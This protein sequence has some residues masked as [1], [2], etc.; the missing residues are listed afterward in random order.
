MKYQWYILF[1]FAIQLNNRQPQYSMASTQALRAL[2]RPM[3]RQATL[4]RP[5]SRLPIAP[6][7][8]LYADTL[9]LLTTA[10]A[11]VVG[12]RT[13]HVEGDDLVVDLTTSKTL[14]GKG[15]KGKTNPEELFAAGYGACFQAAMNAS[16]PAIGLKMPKEPQ[17]SIVETA[18][19]LVGHPKD[20]VM[21]LKVDMKVK[22]RGVTGEDLEKIVAK[23]REVCPYH[24]ATT[25]NVTT[26]IETEVMQ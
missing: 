5:L 10:H 11:K 19:H 12:A 14:G 6:R 22:V 25:G 17:D 24:H 3:A 16:A 15:D 8:T 2:A 20:L 21:R 9:P 4:L 1:S 13:G 23:A 26:T 7:R 18:V